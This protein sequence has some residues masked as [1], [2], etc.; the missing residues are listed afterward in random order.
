MDLSQSQDK[1]CRKS[2]VLFY[3]STSLLQSC[4]SGRAFR[5]GF[6]PKVDKNFGPYLV[7]K[8]AFLS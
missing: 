2:I 5:G 4:M 1:L 6:G 3:L 7:L 8:R